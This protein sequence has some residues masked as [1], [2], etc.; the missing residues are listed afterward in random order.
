MEVLDCVAL[1]GRRTH[2]EV[3]GQ[4]GSPRSLSM[5]PFGSR[6]ESVLGR[7]E[8]PMGAE[9]DRGSN[10]MWLEISMVAAVTT[11]LGFGRRRLCSDG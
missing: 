5:I 3:D 11:T 10:G 9:A 1:F 2:R 8:I 4:R 7:G 6:C